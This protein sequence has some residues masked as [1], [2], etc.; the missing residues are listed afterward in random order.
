MTLAKDLTKKDLVEQ[1]RSKITEI[2]VEEAKA[3]LDKGGA[4]FMDCREP[5]EYK[6]GHIPGAI[7]IPRGLL[8]FKIAKVVPD[9]TTKIVM[10]CRS[11]GRASLACCSLEPMGYKNVVSI[12]GGW[13]AWTKAGYPVE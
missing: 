8:E 4:I 1:A 11:G 2:S 6:Q 5:R 13:L 7:N 9:K 10:Y 3:Q 12:R